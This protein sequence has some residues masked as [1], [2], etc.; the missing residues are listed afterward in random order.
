MKEEE[1]KEAAERS[2][3]K[4]NKELYEQG[5]V[6]PCAYVLGY[7][8]G[9]KAALQQPK[10]S[11]WISC[12]DKY[13]DE[14]LKDINGEIYFLAT[15]DEDFITV[16]R[17]YFDPKTK[18]YWIPFSCQEYFAPQIKIGDFTISMMSDKLDEYKVWIQLEG[19]EGAEFSAKS[20]EPFI[21]DFFD[22]NF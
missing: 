1:I 22:K 2:W 14:S 6:N 18:L 8:G 9:F 19:Q 13:P 5:G 20:L 4:V 3:E 12:L 16:E 10:E 7:K 21:K 15:E 11:E 17:C